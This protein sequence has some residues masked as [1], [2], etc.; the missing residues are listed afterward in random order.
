[1][2]NPKFKTHVFSGKGTFLFGQPVSWRLFIDNAS[3][4]ND[5]TFPLESCDFSIFRQTCESKLYGR[6]NTKIAADND[7]K[8][9]KVTFLGQ[10]GRLDIH[11]PN[12]KQHPPDS[13]EKECLRD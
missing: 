7:G 3:P 2:G 11:T 12:Y 5:H 13:K 9:M 10:N 1:M 8:I 6:V 4:G